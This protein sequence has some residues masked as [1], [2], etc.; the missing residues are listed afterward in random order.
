MTM[1]VND[2]SNDLPQKG[3]YKLIVYFIC[4]VGALG[5]L[6]F[7]LDQGFIA[8]ALET[9]KATYHLDIRGAEKYSAILATGG[10]IGALLS[11]LF[12]RFLGRKKSLVLAGL[13]FSVGSVIS[14]SLPS[15]FWLNVCR[16]F[17]GFGV[18]IASFI[19]P[20]Y[21]SETAPASIRG[22]MGTL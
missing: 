17:L 1:Q 2:M 5:G 21:L 19:T 6:L 11:G 10:V 12:A 14:A 20:L 13:I 22:S 4:L 8:N 7:G 3:N 18:G 16:F 9:I 15:F